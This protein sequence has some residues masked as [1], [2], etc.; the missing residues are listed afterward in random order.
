VQAIPLDVGLDFAIP[1]GLLVTE[2][3]TNSLKHAFPD[4]TGAIAVTLNRSENGCINL[5]V[6][7]DGKGC[8]GAVTV[9]SQQKRGLGSRII[10]GLVA[11][12]EGTLSVQHTHGTRSEL[13]V[14]V[15]VRA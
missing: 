9:P 11:Q 3:V 12:L 4:G 13:R 5:V 1:L 15:P 14:A 10:E 7:D 6:S 8:I 2:L